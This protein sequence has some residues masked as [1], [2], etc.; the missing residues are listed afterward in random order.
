MKEDRPVVAGISISHPDRVFYPDDGITKLELARYYEAI[1]DFIVPHVRGRPLT[2]LRCE[3]TIAHCMFLRHGRAWGPPAL[4]RVRIREKTKLGEYLV[5]DDV[6]G[7]VALAQM[8][9]LEIHTWSSTVDDIE[10]PNRLVFDLDPGEGVGWPDVVKAARLVRKELGA[11]DLEAWVKTTGGKGL[12][13]VVPLR[14]SADWSACLAFARALA[15]RL[16]QREP[17]RFTARMGKAYRAGKIFIDYLR[18]NR[19]NTSI[20][21]FSARARPGAPVSVPLAWEELARARPQTVRTVPAWLQRRRR[22]PWADYW[23]C[24]QRLTAKM[25]RILGA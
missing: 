3:G 2:L 5:A 25:V 1:G 15:E 13:V 8:D 21:A 11:L 9:V 12:H 16:A 17:L 6:A 22:D 4:R 20:A 24:N 18:N 14:P 10:R 7:V 23:R 19:T